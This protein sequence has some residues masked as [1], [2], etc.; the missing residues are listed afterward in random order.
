MKLYVIPVAAYCNAK[1]FFC[2]TKLTPQLKMAELLSL[3]SFSQLQTFKFEKI[4]ITGGGDPLLHPK[5]NQ[6]I[7]GLSSLAP[8]QLYTNGLALKKL[9]PISQKLLSKLCIS[10]AHYNPVVNSKLMGVLINNDE[11]LRQISPQVSLKMSAVLCRSGLN[12]KAEITNYIKWAISLGAK[13]VVFRKLFDLKHSPKYEDEANVDLNQII[14]DL[15]KHHQLVASSQ[16]KVNFIVLGLP[17][18]IELRSCAC[19]L[20]NP[21]LRP[22]GKLYSGWGQHEFH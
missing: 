2:V 7:H 21:V 17:V 16:E 19:E 3:D 14:F 12:S 13:E 11:Y 4:E 8:T 10:R 20:T 5:I 18:E 1:C 6:I 22:N 15:K 9:S